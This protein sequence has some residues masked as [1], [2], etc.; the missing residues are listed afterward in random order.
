MNWKKKK[1]KKKEN[2]PSTLYFTLYS[3]LVIP[4]SGVLH[5]VLGLLT[6]EGHGAV[7]LGPE[8]GYKDD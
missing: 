2:C 7:G 6:Q 1:K 8:E 4:P 5:P 3:A